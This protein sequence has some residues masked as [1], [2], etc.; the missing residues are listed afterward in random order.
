[1]LCNHFCWNFFTSNSKKI[2]INV[3]SAPVRKTFFFMYGWLALLDESRSGIFSLPVAG[4][5]EIPSTS[6]TLRILKL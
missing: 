6:V 5:K 2:T 3:S 1:M 4:K